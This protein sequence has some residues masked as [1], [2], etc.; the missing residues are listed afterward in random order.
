MN[1]YA[2]IEN[3]FVVNVVVADADF[4]ATQP[5]KNYVLCSRGGI[6]WSFDGV[7][8]VAPKPFTSWSLDSN[9]D[10]Q[11][12]T[13]MPNDGKMYRWNEASLAWVVVVG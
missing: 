5:D 1:N 11:A 4:V 2:E 13:A 10:W 7:N 8:F 9:H 3:G 6:G 12:P